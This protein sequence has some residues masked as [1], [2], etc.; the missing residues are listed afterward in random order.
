M[1]VVLSTK[2]FMEEE[3]AALM[4]EHKVWLFYSDFHMCLL[5]LIYI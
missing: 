4:H 1:D 3:L 5:V 2:D